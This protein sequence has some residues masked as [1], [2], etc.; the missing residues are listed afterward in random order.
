MSNKLIIPADM[1][2]AVVVYLSTRPFR[3]VHHLIPALMS[4]QDEQPVVIPADTEATAED[5]VV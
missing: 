1:R 5:S 4:L 2:D 3:E